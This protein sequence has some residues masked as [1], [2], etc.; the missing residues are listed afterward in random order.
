MLLLT[1]A[2]KADPFTRLLYGVEPWYASRKDGVRL[3]SVIDPQGVALAWG[4]YFLSVDSTSSTPRWTN[5]FARWKEESLLQAL[6]LI[7]RHGASALSIP[8]GPDEQVREILSAWVVD[9]AV[10]PSLARMLPH[11][12]SAMEQAIRLFKRRGNDVRV[13]VETPGYAADKIF[14]G[15]LRLP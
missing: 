9:G 5:R 2:S 12:Q 8:N 15:P 13:L 11:R 10:H 1:H 7:A 3:F 14:H 6:D 4:L